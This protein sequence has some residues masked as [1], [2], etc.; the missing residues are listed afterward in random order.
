MEE[1]LALLEQTLKALRAKYAAGDKSVEPRLRAVAAKVDQLRIE[2][3]AK[4][5]PPV[6]LTI[7]EVSRKISQAFRHKCCR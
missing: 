4:A 3:N 7:E 1:N 6:P 2:Q 5:P